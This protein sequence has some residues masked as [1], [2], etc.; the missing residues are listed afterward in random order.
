MK[1]E[2]Y[3]ERHPNSGLNPDYIR[4]GGRVKMFFD[5]E[6]EHGIGA[7]ADGYIDGELVGEGMKQRDST[8]VLTVEIGPFS[9]ANT[10]VIPF[11]RPFRCP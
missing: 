10:R 11:G 7:L 6:N 9:R 8:V 1:F 2:L 3:R 5:D 4:T